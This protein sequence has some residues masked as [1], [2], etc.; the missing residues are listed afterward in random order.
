MVCTGTLTCLWRWIASAAF[1]DAQSTL[2]GL[3]G[4]V[5]SFICFIIM[6]PLMQAGVHLQPGR[7]V[8]FHR[9]SLLILA[10]GCTPGA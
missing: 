2:T 9:H 8:H 4:R 5:Y 3:L 6:M 1:G 7:P 10:G